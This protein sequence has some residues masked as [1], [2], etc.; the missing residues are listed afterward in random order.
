MIRT[1]EWRDFF[2]WL[3]CL[4]QSDQ[5]MAARPT[6]SLQLRAI[7][8]A[9]EALETISPVLT[10]SPQ[11]SF[12]FLFLCFLRKLSS[13]EKLHSTKLN[14][15]HK[16]Y[17]LSRD[18]LFGTQSLKSEFNCQGVCVS[19]TWKGSTDTR[20]SRSLLISRT[21]FRKV[22]AQGNSSLPG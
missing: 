5:K 6:L 1:V 18:I 17:S 10:Q 11:G 20:G 7:A 21:F 3:V 12:I 13:L 8:E 22:R 16:P 4:I 14:L 19:I 9:K 15:F 2:D